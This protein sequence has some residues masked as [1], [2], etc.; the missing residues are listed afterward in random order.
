LKNQATLILRQ[1]NPENLQGYAL[2]RWTVI[3]NKLSVIWF[4]PKNFWLITRKQC[5]QEKN[6]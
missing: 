4:F 2:E 5:Y 6:Y 1:F 3:R